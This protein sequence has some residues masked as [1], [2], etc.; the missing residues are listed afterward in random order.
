MTARQRSLPPVSELT[1]LDAE[2]GCALRACFTAARY[3][4]GAISRIEQAVP[5]P[6]DA[7]RLPLIA[8]FVE[9]EAAPWATLAAI[10]AYDLAQPEDRAAGDLAGLLPRLVE[11][12]LLEIE[13]G[14]VR[15]R[16]RIMPFQSL[17]VLS[18]RPDGGAEAVMGPGPTTVALADAALP[19]VG[20]RV[21]DLGCG[22]GSL[23]L[24]AAATGSVRVVAS[25]LNARAVAVT[26]ANA[27]LNGVDIEVRAGDGFAPVAS[28]RFDLVLCQP[29]YVFR[30]AGAGAVT[31]LHGGI[32]GDE[33]AR[34]L[35]A[36][37]PA[38]LSPAGQAIWSFDAPRCA[39]EQVLAEA[40]AGELTAPADVVVVA[41]PGPSLDLL[42]MGYASL[43]DPTFGTEYARIV[44][45]YRQHCAAHGFLGFQRNLVI[46]RRPAHGFA[47]Q[48]PARAVTRL[49]RT[50]LQRLLGSIDASMLPDHQLSALTIGIVPNA[51]IEERRDC[52]DGTEAPALFRA[53]CGQDAWCAEQELSEA[54]ATLCLYLQRSPDV[55][56]TVAA[57]AEMC[58]AT[59]ADVAPQVLAFVRKGLRQGLL[60]LRTPA[61][62]PSPE[63]L[64]SGSTG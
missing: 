46:L 20:G 28:E 22:A 38:V 19:A 23:A 30:P 40:V 58:G 59:P 63:G 61:P 16:W 51:R 56:Q 12:G 9:R 48:I 2:F 44:R 15:A 35:L 26:E 43:A 1:R 55:G 33:L 62:S 10:F 11:L 50:S 29:P 64:V 17:W 32:R 7:P 8:C 57:Y 47:V 14:L 4:A 49:G 5:G 18:D 36:Q 45:A 34:S 31:Y 21:L 27:R 52:T 60:A 6:F 39:G 25:D 3:D 37:A 54:V 13:A 42:A 24:V 41:S 53:T